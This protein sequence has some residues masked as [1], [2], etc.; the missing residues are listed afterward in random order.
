MSSVHQKSEQG[1]AIYTLSNARVGV[2]V[3]PELGAKLLSL[4]LLSSEREWLWR[5]PGPLRLFRSRP[6]D[7]FASSTLIGADECVPTVQPCTVRGRTL[8]DHGSAW[9][10]P[11]LVD[12]AGLAAGVI[13]TSLRLPGTPLELTRT[14]SLEQACVLL[15]YELANSGPEPEPFLWAFHPLF[16]LKEGDRLRLPSEVRS[17]HLTGVSGLAAA[18][19]RQWAWPEPE[20]GINL[21]MLDLGGRDAFAKLFTG[22]LR[23]GWAR[24][25][26]RLSGDC[27]ELRW[28]VQEQPFL[29]IWLTRGGW[30]GFHHPALEPTNAPCSSLAEALR[31]PRSELFVPARGQ[32]RWG[33]S[34]DLAPGRGAG[35]LP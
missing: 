27:L 1:F 11:W 7:D 14:V 18:A 31:E 9:S 3:I 10:A 34:L 28:P 20:P 19:G 6:G 33:L 16:T 21:E 26:N 29:G 8:P 25:E 12:P 4:R 13:R 2:S 23:Q 32:R 30:H 22:A 24:L 17:L 35:D 15:E 5:P